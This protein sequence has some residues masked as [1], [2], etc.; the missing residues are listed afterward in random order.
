MYRSYGPVCSCHVQIRK[1]SHVDRGHLKRTHGQQWDSN[2]VYGEQANSEIKHP[3]LPFSVQTFLLT[4]WAESGAEFKTQCIGKAFALLAG[5]WRLLFH[6]WFFALSY[7]F[8]VDTHSNCQS[9]IATPANNYPCPP[10][11]QSPPPH[12]QTE[13]PLTH[14]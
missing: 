1:Q 7:R 2:E 12:S 10:A 9:P 6:P 13:Q 8:C 3:S 5:P 11:L 14:F 4:W